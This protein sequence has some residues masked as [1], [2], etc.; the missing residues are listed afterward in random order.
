MLFPGGIGYFMPLPRG[1]GYFMH[2]PGYI[3][4]LERANTHLRNHLYSKK[5]FIKDLS[6][7]YTD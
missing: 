1:I 2:F 3:I 6:W 7:N 5:A 4:H